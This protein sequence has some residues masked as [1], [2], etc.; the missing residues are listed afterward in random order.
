MWEVTDEDFKT[1]ESW[2]LE[3]YPFKAVSDFSERKAELRWLNPEHKEQHIKYVNDCLSYIKD[4]NFDNYYKITKKPIDLKRWEYL[5]KRKA[6]YVM[7]LGWDIITKVGGN[8]ADF[9]CGD[10]DTVQRLIDFI[11]KEC[12]LKNIKNRSDS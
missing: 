12:K 6:W 4:K 8:V 10:G 3:Q 5:M 11:D 2:G 9:G 7:P 1:I